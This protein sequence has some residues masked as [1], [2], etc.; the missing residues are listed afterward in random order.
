MSQSLPALLSSLLSSKA[1][2]TTIIEAGSNVDTASYII[3]KDGNTIYAKNGTTGKVEFQGTDASGV[4]QS[5][6]D[7]L[8]EGGRIYIKQGSYVLT[9]TLIIPSGATS[10]LSIQGESN[11]TTKIGGSSSLSQLITA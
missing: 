8:T 7:N 10:K 6:V 2:P 4:M 9:K 1:A 11:S 5:V 3:F